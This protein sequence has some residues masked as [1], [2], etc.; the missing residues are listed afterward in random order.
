MGWQEKEDEGARQCKELKLIG[1]WGERDRKQIKIGSLI[2]VWG[3]RDRALILSIRM[4]R[5]RRRTR[6]PM[7]GRTHGIKVSEL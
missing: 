3:E 2:G 4:M 5:G 1:V 6:A 7:D